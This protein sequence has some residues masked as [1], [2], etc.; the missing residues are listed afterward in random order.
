MNQNKKK[1]GWWG[2][3]LTIVLLIVALPILFFNS[4]IIYKAR[5]EPDQVPSFLGY[6]PFIVLSGSMQETIKVGDLV[7]VKAVPAGEVESLQVGDIIAFRENKM[8]V[9]HR[10]VGKEVDENGQWHF[11]TKGDF[12]NAN[13]INQVQVADLEG[14]YVTRWPKVGDVLLFIQQPFGFAAILMVLFVLA[15]VMLVGGD[16]GLDKKKQKALEEEVARLR[17]EK[18]ALEKGVK[19]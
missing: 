18:Q 1:T 16:K 17:K 9:T 19:E 11:T 7:W 13:D 15:T 10:I 14:K 4:V 6:K 5:T 2:L 3:F 12:N 8:V